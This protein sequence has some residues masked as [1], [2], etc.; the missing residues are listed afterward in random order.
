MKKTHWVYILTNATH[1]TLYTGVTS[2]LERRIA[3]HRSGKHDG[4]TAKY[5]LHQLVYVQEYDS[6]VTAIEQEK[7]I[8]GGS[9]KRKDALISAKNPEWKDLAPR[10]E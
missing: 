1:S 9:R 2:D 8:K 6:I 3:E 10:G 7:R 5:N 4:F